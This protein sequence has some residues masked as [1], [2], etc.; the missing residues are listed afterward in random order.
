MVMNQCPVR[1]KIRVGLVLFPQPFQASH[2]IK[3]LFSSYPFHQPIIEVVPN[4]SKMTRR[5]FA[6]V[7]DQPTHYRAQVRGQLF[8]GNSLL[9]YLHLLEFTYNAR[10]GFGT[11]EDAWQQHA[12]AFGLAPLRT[13]R[14]T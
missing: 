2:K 12:F 1:K 14:K 8:Y 3:S 5:E 11:D 7:V 13:D 6:M 4:E 9:V 10:F